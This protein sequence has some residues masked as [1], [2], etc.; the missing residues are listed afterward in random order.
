MFPKRFQALCTKHTVDLFLGRRKNRI[1]L[2]RVTPCHHSGIIPIERRTFASTVQCKAIITKNTVASYLRSLSPREEAKLEQSILDAISHHKNGILDPIL[3]RNIRKLGWVQSLRVVKPAGMVGLFSKASEPA[4]T[5]HGKS[6][7][8]GILVHLTL[9]TLMHSGAEQMKHDI[10]RIVSQ[11]V[12]SFLKQQQQSSHN[13]DDK[14]ATWQD[15]IVRVDMNITALKPVPFAHNTDEQDELIKKLGPGLAN[16]RHFLAVYSCKGGV[17]KSTVAANL[18]YELSRMGGRVGLLDVDIYGPSLPVLVKPND[19]AVRR[20]S[21]GPGIVKPI[22]HMGVKM[23]SLGFVSP[24]SG[25]PGSGPSGGAAVMRGP[26]AGRVVTQLLKG[27]EWGELD[28]LVLDMPPGTGDVQLTICQDLEL[29]G[30]VSVTTPSKLAAT[31]AAK[32]IEMF[33]SLGVRTLAI[34]ENMSYFDCEGGSR[35]YP[36]GK[37]IQEKTEFLKGSDKTP[38]FQ[39]P[40]SSLMNEANDDG[41]PLCLSRPEKAAVELNRFHELASTVAK[42]LLLLEYGS[43]DE[44]SEESSVQIDGRRFDVNSL[45]LS[46]DNKLNRFIVRLFSDSGATQV[47]IPGEKLRLWHPKLGV[48]MDDVSGGGSDN[49]KEGKSSMVTHTSSNGCA[50]HSH[51]QGGQ[52]HRLFPCKLEKKG[53][54]GYAVEWADHSTIIYSMYSLA[55]AAGG[56]S[57]N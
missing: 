15:D 43:S 8:A 20:S 27:T 51:D 54:Y 24:T 30:A 9:P 25:V 14:D 4:D 44:T 36:F 16:V 32:G 31:D 26:M 47:V 35:H 48:P 33:T 19:P 52:T 17:G 13:N 10:Q 28:V 50:S 5:L 7:D 41:C 2:R 34:V 40:I 55:R 29:S 57:C 53:R 22:E 42:E 39:F 12:V 38:I 23:L 56:K 46:V 21:I 45:H 49:T 6:T 3:Q 11:Q 18:A 1:P 37:S